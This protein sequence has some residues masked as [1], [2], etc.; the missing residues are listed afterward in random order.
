M[1]WRSRK[2]IVRS[3]VFF[4]VS[5][6]LLPALVSGCKTRQDRPEEK[7]EIKKIEAVK[8]KNP[9]L[10]VG[11]C[12]ML[13]MLNEYLGRFNHISG[14]PYAGLVESFGMDEQE[15][16]DRFEEM[17]LAYHQ[18]TGTRFSLKRDPPGSGLVFKSHKLSEIINSF[19]IV[20]K[21]KSVSGTLD[22]KVLDAASENCRLAFVQ[23]A[24]MRFGLEG[25]NAIRMANGYYKIT[26]LAHVLEGLGC[27]PVRIYRMETVP[28]SYVLV[29]RPTERL[30]ELLPIRRKLRKEELKGYQEVKE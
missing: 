21:G 23:G 27:K 5:A 12:R 14:K 6:A 17:I 22:L 13:G 10:T 24:Y 30:K 16:A 19:Y 18:E 2:Q 11:M 4:L 7:N 9:D 15:I 1:Q 8:E 29:F 26:A 28:M 20:E 3:L 25:A